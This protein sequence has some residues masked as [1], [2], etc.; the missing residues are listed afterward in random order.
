MSAHLAVCASGS[1]L[2]LFIYLLEELGQTL[3]LRLGQKRRVRPATHQLLGW[4][5]ENGT[6][7]KQI[8]VCQC[9]KNKSCDAPHE[10]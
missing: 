9:G 4:L 2:F 6:P 8:S 1:G 7:K 10:L 5:G 3:P